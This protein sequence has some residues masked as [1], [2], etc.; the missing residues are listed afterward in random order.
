MFRKD[1][2]RILRRDQ[3]RKQISCN[4]LP[5]EVCILQGMFFF[6]FFFS[7]RN[8]N[9]NA[10]QFLAGRNM[11]ESFEDLMLAVNESDDTQ[12]GIALGS[13]LVFLLNCILYLEKTKAW[14]FK[15][16][17]LFIDA[18]L[19]DKEAEDITY[20]NIETHVL[21]YFKSSEHL[22]QFLS[23]HHI[24][25]AK[26]FYALN[27][28]E[29]AREEVVESRKYCEHVAN[30]YFQQIRNH[31]VALINLGVLNEK[32]SHILAVARRK[33]EEGEKD[34]HLGDSL[35]E[36]EKYE[37]ELMIETKISMNEIK[38]MTEFAS[39]KVFIYAFWLFIKAE[40]RRLKISKI[41]FKI[42]TRQGKSVE[43]GWTFFF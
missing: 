36:L 31:W 43:E 42:L 39:K 25:K 8:I 21:N 33:L 40:R 4:I 24:L 12:N 41:T 28:F 26:Y 32:Y 5:R 19:F 11:E 35:Q 38:K 3:Q 9:L 18:E 17:S 16:R 10:L 2:K 23:V 22:L 14:T 30:Q 37:K 34:L 20:D 29:K 27:L 1:Q 13:S 15:T 6:V 7:K